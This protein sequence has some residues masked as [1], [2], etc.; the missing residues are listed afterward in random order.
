MGSSP[1]AR[2][3]GRRPPARY[4]RA[5][6]GLR[7]REITS[8]SRIAGSQAQARGLPRVPASGE[9]A[10][11]PG[12]CGGDAAGFVSSAKGGMVA[13]AQGGRDG[14]LRERASRL[15]NGGREGRES[16]V[17]APEGPCVRGRHT[18]GRHTLAQSARRL[19]GSS[20]ALAVDP[21]R[22]PG[23]LGP[24]PPPAPPP[25][26]PPHPRVVHPRP[27]PEPLAP[28]AAAVV[29]G[30]WGPETLSL[31]SPPRARARRSVERRWSARRQTTGGC[32]ARAERARQPYRYRDHGL[33]E[34]SK[35][36]W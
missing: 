18:C 36:G 31:P 15:P 11:G 33:M 28:P 14:V 12:T 7:A 25:P 10:G 2:G 5:C 1:G 9:G 23:F 34:K 3:T 16:C 19:P 27:G 22:D 6:G 30:R 21:P 32:E 24:A 13:R 4:S 26:A 35:E 29:E 8:G 20:S 17:L